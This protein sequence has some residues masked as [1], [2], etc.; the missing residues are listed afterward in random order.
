M[1]FCDLVK[2]HR[3]TAGLSQKALADKVKVEPAY[4]CDIEHGRKGPPPKERLELFTQAFKLSPAQK[5]Q[6]LSVAFRERNLDE[7]EKF[8]GVIPREASVLKDPGSQYNDSGIVRGPVL[9]NCTLR[10]PHCNKLHI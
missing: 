1:R 10:F 9:G 6:F 4:I 3:L 8:E 2:E 5:D 7:L